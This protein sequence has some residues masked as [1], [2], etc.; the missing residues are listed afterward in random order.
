MTAR[1]LDGLEA[2]LESILGRGGIESQCAL[3]ADTGKSYRSD[4]TNGRCCERCRRLERNRQSKRCLCNPGRKR[5][6]GANTVYRHC[7]APGVPL[8]HWWGS[9]EI[10][11]TDRDFS[12]PT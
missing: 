7:N 11:L 12:R 9:E 10:R 2:G 8:T 1:F 5:Q 3:Q 6:P 4:T